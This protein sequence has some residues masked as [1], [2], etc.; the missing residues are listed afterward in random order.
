M[1]TSPETKMLKKE[2]EKL[3]KAKQRSQITPEKIQQRR[4]ND[5]MKKAA[6]RNMETPEQAESRREKNAENMVILRKKRLNK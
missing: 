2:K 4:E 1:V 6:S 3:R 5:K